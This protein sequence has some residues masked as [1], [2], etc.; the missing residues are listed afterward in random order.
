MSH[1]V[2]LSAIITSPPKGFER[3]RTQPGETLAHVVIRNFPEQW[4]GFV[5]ELRTDY[6]V[7]AAACDRLLAGILDAADLTVRAKIED[8]IS[9][10]LP[11]YARTIKALVELQGELG[12]T[13]GGFRLLQT[14]WPL[15]QH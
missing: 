13:I 14:V 12:Q 8:F 11:G 2:S 1:K 10:R 7:P 15:E 3:P 4:R 9:N 5:E 6:A